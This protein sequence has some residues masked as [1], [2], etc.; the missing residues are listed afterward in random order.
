MAFTNVPG[1]PQKLA[2][3]DRV[4]EDVQVVAAG[5]GTCG[6]IMTAFSYLNTLRVNLCVDTAIMDKNKIEKFT[7]E[8]DAQLDEILVW[9]DQIAGE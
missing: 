1:P 2:V 5:L 9:I 6:T 3:G 8:F 4:I 7:Q